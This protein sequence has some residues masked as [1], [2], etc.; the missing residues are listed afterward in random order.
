MFGSSCYDHPE[1]GGG[2]R[3]KEIELMVYVGLSERGVSGMVVLCCVFVVRTGVEREE[4]DAE[5][6]RER[7]QLCSEKVEKV[8]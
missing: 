2:K 7:R 3:E 8:V 6:K 1:I 5:K 4:Q